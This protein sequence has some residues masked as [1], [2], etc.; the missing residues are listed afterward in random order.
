VHLAG[1]ISCLAMLVACTFGCTSDDTARTATVIPVQATLPR[2][3]LATPSL[4]A[5]PPPSQPSPS[6][7]PTGETYTVR[8]GD[9]LSSIAERFLGDASEWNQIFV[10]NRDQL[11]SPDA[12]QVGMT[13][14]I[15]PRSRQ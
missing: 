6:P 8:S 4:I 12:L 7:A 5:S 3:P 15:P 10:A 11:S 14:R 2:P 13:I 9:T 1:R